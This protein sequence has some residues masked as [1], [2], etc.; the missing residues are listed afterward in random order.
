MTGREKDRCQKQRKYFQQNPRRKLSNLRKEI[1]IKDQKAYRAQSRNI[2]EGE[3]P[4][5]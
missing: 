4:C 1:S 2:Q 3:T 5:F